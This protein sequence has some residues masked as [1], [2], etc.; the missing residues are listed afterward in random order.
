MEKERIKMKKPTILLSLDTST[1]DTGVAFFENGKF[2]HS[3]TIDVSTVKDSEKRMEQMISSLYSLFADIK[4]DIVVVEL[5]SVL[6]NPDTQRKLTMVLGAV[7]GKCIEM[8]ILF[9]SYRPSEWRSLVKSKNEKLPRKREE[10]KQWALKKCH[11]LGYV[12]IID[13]NEAEA[14]LIGHAYI[15]QWSVE[16]EG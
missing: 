1:K 16:S 7:M 8:Y 2:S 5:T 6:R 9:Y 13:D 14:V 4:P 10:L 3:E 11:E 12:D 15:N